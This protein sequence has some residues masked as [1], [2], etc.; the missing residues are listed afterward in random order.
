ML[1]L[2]PARSAFAGVGGRREKR[3]AMMA[4]MEP[5]SCETN[6]RECYERAGGRFGE[7]RGRD[8]GDAGVVD[9]ARAREARG[10]M[11][12]WAWAAGFTFPVRTWPRRGAG[13]GSFTGMS[14]ISM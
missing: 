10:R 14:I 2:W 4:N 1:G 3:A 8:G 7:K 5:P 12:G 11:G 13:C 9:C 6:G